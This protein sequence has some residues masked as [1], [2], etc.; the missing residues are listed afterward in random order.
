[1]NISPA[2]LKLIKSFEGLRLTT[3]TCAAGVLTIGY[4]STGA[5]ATPGKTITE[6]EAEA[7]LLK[8]LTRFE[9][10]VNELVKVPMT[11]GAY[12][13]LVSFAFN[14][15]EGALAESTLLRKLNAGEDPNTV[16]KAELPRWTNSGLAGL[17]RRRAAEVELFCSG[18]SAAPAA[19]A[20]VSITAMQATLLKKRPVAGTELADN[21]KVAVEPGKAYAGAK[22]LTEENGHKLL[23]L[24]G[25]AGQWFVYPSHWDGFAPKPAAAPAAPSTG[26]GVKL[27]VKYQSQR[28]NKTS[29]ADNAGRTC[30]SSSCAMLA[31]TVKP[32]CVANDDAYIQKRQPFGD[33]TDGGAQV[34]CLKSLGIN[35][36]F[37]QS[38]NN[39]TIKKQL[40]RGIPVP[41]G[42][43]H[44]GPASAPSGGGH[45]I[46][47]IGYDA[48]GFI[49]H[50]PWGEI[51][52]GS[53]TYP[54]TDGAS[55]HYS[56]KLFDSRWTVAGN[57]DGWAV[58][59]D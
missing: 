14:C 58:L 57:S 51:D 12:D 33:S 55:K 21:E 22:V 36:R 25:G 11:Q 31:M 26:S 41:V 42:I 47:V 29:G 34:K 37:T 23:E 46:C 38:G 18:G 16:A 9:K 59:V 4:G 6:A 43:L 5:H 28:D 56:Y 48:T 8:D 3:Y 19:A 13:A 7:L 35:A 40:D 20:T 39:D 17:V 32:G 30:F 52:H 15:G 44:H 2:G 27:A 54:S 24:P 45:W 53:G 10:A 50:D 49:V 1:V